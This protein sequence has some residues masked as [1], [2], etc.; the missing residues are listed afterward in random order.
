[1]FVSLSEDSLK[2]KKT[3]FERT[4]FDMTERNCGGVRLPERKQSSHDLA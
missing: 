3:A 2:N 1:M 4:Q